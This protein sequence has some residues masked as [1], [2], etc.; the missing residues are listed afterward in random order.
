MDQ[1]VPIDPDILVIG[2][3]VTGLFTAYW[4]KHFTSEACNVVVLERDPT[5]SELLIEQEIVK[6]SKMYVTCHCEQ[7]LKLKSKTE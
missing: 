5:V 7:P 4:L 3:G 1:Q 2:G 6:F